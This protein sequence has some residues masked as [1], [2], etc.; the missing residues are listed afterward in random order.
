MKSLPLRP[1]ILCVQVVISFPGKRDV[2]VVL[3]RLGKLTS[4]IHRLDCSAKV[5]KCERLR[6]VV[7]F[8]LRRCSTHRP[9]FEVGRAAHPW[10][11]TPP[12]QRTSVLAARSDIENLSYHPPWTLSVHLLHG[13]AQCGQRMAR[14]S[15]ALLDGDL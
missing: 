4:A 2:C 5:G 7:F 15:I 1:L 12:R 6:H 13:S 14:I 11:G 10:A 3:L 8:D 9:A